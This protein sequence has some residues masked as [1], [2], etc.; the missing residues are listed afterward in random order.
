MQGG[1]SLSLLNGYA[2]ARLPATALWLEGMTYMRA[3]PLA[4]LYFTAGRSP[5]ALFEHLVVSPSA[6]EYR[7]PSPNRPRSIG[8]QKLL[9]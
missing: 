9:S 4:F 5:S 8:L 3:K 1:M 7:F 2:M 6:F